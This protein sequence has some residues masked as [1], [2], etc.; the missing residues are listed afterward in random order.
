MLEKENLGKDLPILQENLTKAESKLGAL[1]KAVKLKTMQISQA[2]AFTERRL[3]EVISSGPS[4]LE[5]NPDLVP[6]LAL[7]QERD[8]FNV[9]TE[10]ELIKPVH[11]ANFLLETLKTVECLSSRDPGIVMEVCKERLGDVKNQLLESV[12]Q[13]WIRPG[14]RNSMGSSI[15]SGASKRD[16]EDK[17]MDR[18]NRQRITSPSL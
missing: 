3:A 13:R 16:R 15:M 7:L 4:S 11:E 14:R 10:N 6:L 18:I 8:N 2:S 17:S 12:K 1:E 9:D 5:G